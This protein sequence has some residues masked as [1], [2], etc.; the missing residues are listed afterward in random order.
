M[1][2]RVF[3]SGRSSCLSLILIIATFSIAAVVATPI[4]PYD[5]HWLQPRVSKTITNLKVWLGRYNIQQGKWATKGKPYQ[6]FGQQIL[7]ICFSLDPCFAVKPTSKGAVKFSE[8]PNLSAASAQ[9]GSF[10]YLEGTASFFNDR[11]HNDPENRKRP[12]KELVYDVLKDVSKLQ[13][14]LRE[15]DVDI[16]ITDDVTYVTAVL[17][18]VQKLGAIDRPLN[19]AIFN[20]IVDNS[21]KARK[22][23]EP[24]KKAMEQP[25]KKAEDRKE[26]EERVKKTMSLGTLINDNSTNNNSNNNSNNNLIQIQPTAIAGWAYRPRS[27]YTSSLLESKQASHG[28]RN[29][30]YDERAVEGVQALVPVLVWGKADTNN[31]TL[32]KDW[33]EDKYRRQKQFRRECILCHIARRSDINTYYE[34]EV[35]KR[36]KIGKPT[37][38]SCVCDPAKKFTTV[39]QVPETSITE[40]Q[41]FAS[42]FILLEVVHRKIF[43]YLATKKP[44]PVKRL[45]VAAIPSGSGQNSG[46]KDPG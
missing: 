43:P 29:D 46:V 20:Q 19:M 8:V 33:E 14:S 45:T 42:A 6:P 22:E 13:A 9:P 12:D 4:A 37:F 30:M 10:W 39:P 16:T 32:N 21:Q 35:Q 44:S 1:L 2:Y 17:E 18:Y 11:K 36:F 24:E 5:H 38:E 40:P 28:R 31:L 23:M 25:E 7:S 15:L 34:N 3:P 41:Y 26:M 27:V